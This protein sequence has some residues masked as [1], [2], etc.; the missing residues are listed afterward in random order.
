MFGTSLD[1]LYQNKLMGHHE[2]TI[3]VYENGKLLRNLSLNNDP[4]YKNEN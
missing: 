2:W 1:A 4:E 3:A